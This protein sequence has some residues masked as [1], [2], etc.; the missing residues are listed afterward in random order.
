MTSA[1]HQRLVAH[2]NRALPVVIVK[3]SAVL[4]DK[5]ARSEGWNIFPPGYDLFSQFGDPTYRELQS[6]N[7][8]GLPRHV[9]YLTLYTRRAS[10]GP[11]AN[12][13]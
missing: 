10:D 6:P 7:Y 9:R 13:F 5:R 1:G 8:A 11:L 4:S 12:Y 3:P 2:V